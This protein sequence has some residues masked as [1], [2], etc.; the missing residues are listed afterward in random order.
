MRVALILW[1]FAS[2]A[3]AGGLEFVERWVDWQYELPSLSSAELDERRRSQES[4]MIFDVR[5]AEE[6]AVSHIPGAIP[7]S[8][9]MTAE[10]FYQLFGSQL[11]AS[12][13]F[14]CSV[15]RRSGALV[16]RLRKHAPSDNEKSS[17][18]FWNLRGGIFRWAIDN[19]ELVNAQGLTRKV[20]PYSDAWAGLLPASVPV[21]YSV[22]KLTTT[23]PTP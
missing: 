10:S 6:F 23:G 11:G 1:L 2:N 18:S 17:T 8:P 21:S 5:E 22:E 3:S 19:Q 16:K 9:D 4:L 14:Y 13:V 7:I 15:G 20:H 12:A